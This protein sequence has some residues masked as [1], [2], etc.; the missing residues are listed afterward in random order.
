MEQQG[1]GGSVGRFGRR[2]GPNQ[3]AGGKHQKRAKQWNVQQNRTD[4]NSTKRASQPAHHELHCGAVVQHFHHF[5]QHVGAARHHRQLSVVANVLHCMHA[6]GGCWGA[7][8]WGGQAEC[9]AKQT[10]GPA[11]SVANAAHRF[12]CCRASQASPPI[13]TCVRPQG[14]IQRHRDHA[15]RVGGGVHQ[16]PLWRVDCRWAKQARAGTQV[17]GEAAGAGTARAAA[18][19]A[20]ACRHLRLPTPRPPLVRRLAWGSRRHPQMHQPRPS[21]LP[22]ALRRPLQQRKPHSRAACLSRGRLW[23]RAAPPGAPAPTQ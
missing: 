8:Q 17:M 19:G 2:E 3:M 1:G 4:Q 22:A 6:G 16:A 21:S 15:V 12:P 20:P 23:S 10:G 18:G 11:G 5:G 9:K 13:Q 14:V 7:R